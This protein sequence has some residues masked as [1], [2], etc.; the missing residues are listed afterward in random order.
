MMYNYG[1][2]PY[3]MMS[4]FGIFGMIIHIALW[5]LIIWGIIYALRKFAGYHHKSHSALDI[6]KHRYAK[7]EIS[8][9]EFESIKKDLE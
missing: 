7:G 4:D 9:E 2:Y 8:K 6:L 5:V 3:G 1:F